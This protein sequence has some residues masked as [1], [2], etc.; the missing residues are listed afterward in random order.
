MCLCVLCTF[1]YVCVCCVRA[2]MFVLY[3]RALCTCVYV[4]VLCMCVYVCV[5]CG[6]C[7]YVLCT[8]VCCVRACMCMRV[9]YVRVCVG[10]VYVRVCV[11]VSVFSSE[12]SLV[13]QDITAFVISVLIMAV[14][15]F[16][17]LLFCDEAKVY[18]KSY[19]M[20][21]KRK[22]QHIFFFLCQNKSLNERRA[23]LNKNFIADINKKGKTKFHT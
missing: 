16:H 9:M 19:K 12:I 8:C 22:K 21:D 6:T 2:C 10:V 15:L 23:T 7:V 11:Y 20:N 5:C 18:H 17:T 13:S 3:V 1:V 4:C 14:C